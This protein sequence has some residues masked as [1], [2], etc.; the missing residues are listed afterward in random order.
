[1]RRFVVFAAILS[2]CVI[3]SVFAHDAEPLTLDQVLGDNDDFDHDESQVLQEDR[4]G[5]AYFTVT[6]TGG[7]LW[8]DYHIAIIDAQY[9]GAPDASGVLITQAISTLSDYTVDIALNGDG[10]WQ[11][12]F[13]FYNSPMENGDTAVFQIYTDNTVSNVDFFGLKAYPTPV[14]EPATMAIL[15]LG[16]LTLLRR[17][18]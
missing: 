8:G 14:P 5:W 15:G 3:S 13:E 6:N 9:T 17:K 7:A 11:A 10:Y 12:N 4:K 18:K 2:V 16:S 1:M